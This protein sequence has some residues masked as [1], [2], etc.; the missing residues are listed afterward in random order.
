MNP[1][2]VFFADLIDIPGRPAFQAEIATN[3]PLSALAAD[4]N[5]ALDGRQAATGQ[6][7]LNLEDANQTV[8]AKLRGQLAPLMPDLVVPF[9]AGNSEFNLRAIRQANGNFFD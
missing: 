3:G 8:E 2:K 1:E 4:L 5:I 9:V 7:L 6:L